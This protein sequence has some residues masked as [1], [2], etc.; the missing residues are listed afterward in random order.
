ML[1]DNDN[2][3]TAHSLNQVPLVHI[4][5]EPRQLADGGKLADI[6]PTMLTLMDIP[7]PAEMTGNVLVK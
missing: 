4:S 5:S 3:V 6:A 7:V 2:V 1:D